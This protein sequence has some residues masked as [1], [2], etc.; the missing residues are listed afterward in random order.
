MYITNTFRDEMNMSS[1]D[2]IKLVLVI[3]S[4]K[5]SKF[6]CNESDTQKTVSALCTMELGH[7]LFFFECID[8]N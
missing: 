7:D 6:F 8:C 4:Y 1:H 3:D 2:K 5:I